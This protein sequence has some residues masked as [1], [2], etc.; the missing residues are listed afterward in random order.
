MNTELQDIFSEELSKK[1]AKEHKKLEKFRRQEE[2]RKAKKERELEKRENREFQKRIDQLRIEPKEERA[3]RSERHEPEVT[4]ELMQELVTLKR[5]PEVERL[6]K[7]EKGSF[8][9]EVFL[10]LGVVG[11]ILSSVDYILFCYFKNQQELV[12][13][14]ILAGT[15]VFFALAVTVQHKGFQKF[16]RFLACVAFIGYM[17]YQMIFI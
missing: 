9:G 3:T 13:A 17:I 1:E 7:Q 12:P 16:F 4:R 10:G 14:G 6:E 2:K 15:T 8:L 11:L 5:Q